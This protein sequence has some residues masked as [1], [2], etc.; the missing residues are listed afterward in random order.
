MLKSLKKNKPAFGI[1]GNNRKKGINRVLRTIIRYF[2]SQNIAYYLDRKLTSGLSGISGRKK[3]DENE[4]LKKSDIIVSIG[5]DGTLLNISRIIGS[6]GI[7]VI[8]INLGTLGFMADIMPDQIQGFFNEI[9]RGNYKIIE[10][11][12]AEYS[13]NGKV[14]YNALNEI[15]IDKSDSIKMID[16]EIYYNND[17]VGRFYADGVLISTPTGSTGYSLS[18][19]GPIVTP[20]SEVFIIT[21]ICPHS[22]N[23]RPVIVPDNGNIEI[24]TLSSEKIRVTPDGY[25]SNVRKSPVRISIKKSRHKLKVIKSEKWSYFDTLNRKLLWGEDIRKGKR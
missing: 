6:T 8:G 4:L 9:L 23:F 15:V 16:L 18:S 20:F 12:L 1:T 17:F 19:G 21:P 11:C 3:V 7:P 22:L 24:R 10:L 14:Q 13:L 25:K 2:D 5:G